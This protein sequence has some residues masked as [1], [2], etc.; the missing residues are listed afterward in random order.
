MRD[1]RIQRIEGLELVV[2]PRDQ[3]ASVV[4][5]VYEGTKPVPF[6]FKIQSEW[7]KASERGLTGSDSKR[8]STGKVYPIRHPSLARQI[9]CKIM[10][11]Q[12]TKLLK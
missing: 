7:S 2:V 5:D 1:R 8:G 6:E 10:S 12:K 3:A 4:F 9:G 11:E